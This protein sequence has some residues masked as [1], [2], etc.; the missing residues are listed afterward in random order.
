MKNINPTELSQIIFDLEDLEL[1]KISDIKERVIKLREI[2]FP[3]LELLQNE[4]LKLVKD[5][6]KID[7]Y[8]EAMSNISTPNNRL[9]AKTNIPPEAV[10]FGRTGKRRNSKKEPPLKVLNAKGKFNYIH[11]AILNY[12]I[13]DYGLMT[14]E[15]APFLRS[16]S[17]DFIEEIRHYILTNFDLFIS[18][19]SSCG[20]DYIN[21]NLEQINISENREMF[22]ETINSRNFGFSGS[23]NLIEFCF[24]IGLY[25]PVEPE[26]I[27]KLQRAYTCIYPLL[28]LCTAIGDG[29][30]CDFSGMLEKFNDSIDVN[31]DPPENEALP[32]EI[33]DEDSRKKTLQSIVQRQGQAKFRKKLLEA[34]NSQ[35][36]ITD[37]N[38][39]MALE[40]AHIFPYK[41]E[42][43]NDVSNGLLLRAD[44]H[45]L[46]DLYL[47][48]IN[49]ETLKVELNKQLCNSSYQ[50]LA[51]KKIKIPPNNSDK[52]NIY[53]LKSHYQK[54]LEKQENV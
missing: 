3:R 34:Y 9:D 48:S 33:P 29:R 19:I 17:S 7:P 51:N 44:I 53:V 39:E 12:T 40:A 46:F 28:Q 50:Y 10:R 38:V 22:F 31:F 18:N 52:P 35:C 4:T 26:S 6:Y 47:I 43:T 11:S 32:I 49:P 42:K 16:V 20:F 23:R 36:A 21:H 24:F 27:F 41:G 2:F 5:I 54:F 15:F 30:D 8:D 1:F 45:T 14:V 13:Y 37:C 25:L